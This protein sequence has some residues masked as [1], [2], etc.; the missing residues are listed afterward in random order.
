MASHAA[1]L[2][3][4]LVM[5]LKLR[6]LLAAVFSVLVSCDAQPQE[7]GACR[8]MEILVGFGAGGGTDLFARH[9]AEGM[10]SQLNKPVTV[11]NYSAGAG[12]AAFRE[13]F[14]R[15]ANGCTILAI[16]SDYVV[17]SAFQPREIDLSKLTFIARAHIEVG[18]LSANG[19]GLTDWNA[20][21]LDARKADRPLLIGGI[22]A[23]S[24]D[25]S[26]VTQAL[27]G[28]DLRFRYIPYDSTKEMQADLLGHRLDAVY[29]EFGVMKPLYQSG[30]AQ[31]LVVLNNDRIT[32]L[33]DTPSA[34]ELGLVSPPSIWRGVALSAETSDAAVR[35]IEDLV[36]TAMMTPAYRQYEQ[37]RGLNLIDG[38]ADGSTFA[39][40]VMR[41]Q[42]SVINALVVQ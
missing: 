37:D 14:K 8:S 29:D 7:K 34:P 12:R 27:I 5:P 42:M 1:F 15:P 6:F 18:L 20:L 25:R 13:L 11:I 23:R 24:F 10:A 2:E 32:P 38:R 28:T 16:T 4:L 33:P 31:P 41:E 22:G 35:A 19:R 40:D 26:V 36:T 17:L 39:V 30:Q 9:L 21:I 3:A